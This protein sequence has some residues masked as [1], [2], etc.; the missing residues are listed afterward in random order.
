[1]NKQKVTNFF[2]GIRASATKHSPEI[3]TA[4]GIAG[5]IGT[6]VMAVTATP[7]ALRLIDK[8]EKDEDRKLTKV[9]VV[10]VTWKQYLPATVTGVVSI[11]CL[12]GANSVH[13]KRN[14]ALAT[15]YQLS[16]TAYNEY[17]DKVVET[18]GEKKEKTIHDKV[19]AERIEKNPVSQ[20]QVIITGN[21][22]SLC[23]DA[24]ADR[25]FESSIDRIKRAVNDLNY[26]MI[27]GAEMSISLNE[28]YT[29]IGLK[30]TPLG[31]QLGWRIDK[32]QID[33]N[34]SSQ[35]TDD[36]R[37]CIVIEYLVPP[38]YGFNDLY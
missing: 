12:I 4:I 25:Y 31:E 6:T 17:R 9:E 33:I 23:Y 36:D 37:P 11:G 8:A 20:N 21:G 10:K 30:Q 13:A 26:R 18:I 28:F 1:M 35:L 34:F 5:M 14:A 2:K 27:S 7:K 29:A 38:E 32:G 16:T 22:T 24:A 15:A 3:L 19:A